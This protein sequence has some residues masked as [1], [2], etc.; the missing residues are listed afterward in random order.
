M[1]RA[2]RMSRERVQEHALDFGAGFRRAAFD[3]CVMLCAGRA[4]HA[5]F[6]FR[7]VFRTAQCK[8][9]SADGNKTG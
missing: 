7:S 8:A 2:Q 5:I 1:L 4:A 6:A 3:G 9:D